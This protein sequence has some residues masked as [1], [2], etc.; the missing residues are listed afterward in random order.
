MIVIKFIKALFVLLFAFLKWLVKFP[1]M[2]WRQL[3]IT[4]HPRN[5]F[6]YD[7]I[8]ALSSL[9]LFFYALSGVTFELVNPISQAFEDV[10]LTDILFSSDKLEKNKDLRFGGEDN[11]MVLNKNITLV[12]IANINRYEISEVVRFVN[13][14]NPK[15][16]GLDV[17][18]EG[19]R[20]PMIDSILASQFSEVEN[21]IFVSRLDSL[22]NLKLKAKDQHLYSNNIYKSEYKSHSLFLQHGTKG[23]ANMVTDQKASHMAICREYMHT[24][25]NITTKEIVNSFPVEIVR[26][27][28]PE[29]LK[30]LFARNKK[31]EIIDFVGNNFVSVNV[32]PYTPDPSKVWEKPH[33]YTV[34]YSQILNAIENPDAPSLLDFKQC[35][36]DKIILM[37]YLGNR[38]DVEEGGEDLFYTP[39]NEK[40]V[41]KAHKDMYGMVVHANIIDSI[42]RESYIDK[43]DERWMDFTGFFVLYFVFALYRP[44]YDDMKIWYDGLTK[45]IGIGISL[46]LLG[47]IGIVFEEFN[48]QITF[49]AI[50]FGAILLA[51]DWLEIYYGV[52]KNIAKVIRN[53]IGVS[54]KS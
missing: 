26:K 19:M 2:I 18:F 15:V 43:T 34:D 28:K 54:I 44:I 29:A 45:I 20:V 7:N 49:G 5:F 41:G 13:Q 51:G 8:F 37:G 48:Y 11:L 31:V 33:F 35:F 3:V 22:N 47:V 50:W 9:L 14:Y 25:K 42:L 4:L 46:A 32:L 38:V 12:N 6:H 40:Y 52:I 23:F 30:A 53:I 10:E 39:L 21:L 27:Y 24:A 36:K 1:L 17:F 16:I